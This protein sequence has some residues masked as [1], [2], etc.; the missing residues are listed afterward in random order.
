MFEPLDHTKRISFILSI[1][2]NVCSD[3]FAAASLKTDSIDI[4]IMEQFEEK[5][6]QRG[7]NIGKPPEQID[8]V[9]GLA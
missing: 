3:I 8:V 9:T 1:V 6:R 5:K 7:V 2:A 4:E